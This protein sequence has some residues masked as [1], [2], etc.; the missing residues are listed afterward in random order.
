MESIRENFYLIE[1]KIASTDIIS[2]KTVF[3]S[4][5]NGTSFLNEI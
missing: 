5:I 2:L 1:N 3:E 4:G